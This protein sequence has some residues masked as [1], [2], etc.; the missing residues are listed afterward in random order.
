MLKFGLNDSKLKSVAPSNI[1]LILVTLD[2]SH[3]LMSL[4]KDSAPLNI[5]DI[6][7]T[8][9]TSHSPMSP[10]VKIIEIFKRW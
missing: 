7:S 10:L 8:F 9:D 3:P 4:L 6:S 2:T 1:S 5:I